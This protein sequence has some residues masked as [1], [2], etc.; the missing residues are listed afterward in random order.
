MLNT[1]NSLQR[2]QWIHIA[3]SVTIVMKMGITRL[4]M[5]SF[6]FRISMKKLLYQLPEFIVCNF[7]KNIRDVLRTHSNIYD[8]ACC[9]NCQMFS[10]IFH[11]RCLTRFC[12]RLSKCSRH[13]LK[14]CK[15]MFLISW[16]FFGSYFLFSRAKFCSNQ[17]RK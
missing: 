10:Q 16:V 7:L 3:I 2:I 6:S 17:S 12:M 4:P 15:I 5:L 8:K 11:V 9:N 1:Q 13:F 14:E